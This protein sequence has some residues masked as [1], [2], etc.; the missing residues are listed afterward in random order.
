VKVNLGSTL[1]ARRKYSSSVQ[2]LS[3]FILYP[4]GLMAAAAETAVRAIAI[5]E[6]EQ[7]QSSLIC[8]WY[9]IATQINLPTL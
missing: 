1:T 2:D 6:H 9:R 4:W 3:S 8:R 5:Y 7:Q